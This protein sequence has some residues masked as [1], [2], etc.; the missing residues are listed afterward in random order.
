MQNLRSY[1]FAFGRSPDDDNH[2][3]TDD[4]N[5]DDD[6]DKDANDACCISFLSVGIR[7]T[8]YLSAVG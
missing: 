8:K 1:C 3:S 5:R 4:D 7:T 6:D 2:D